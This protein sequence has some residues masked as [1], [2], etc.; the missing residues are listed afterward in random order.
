MTGQRDL[1]F[2]NQAEL[3]REP[4]MKYRKILIINPGLILAKKLFFWLI[5]EALCATKREVVR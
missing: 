2:A 4:F 5:F 1:I 3:E